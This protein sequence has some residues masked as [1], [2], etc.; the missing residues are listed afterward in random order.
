VV[1]GFVARTQAI[2]NIYEPVGL[3]AT[4]MLRR[5]DLGQAVSVATPSENDMYVFGIVDRLTGIT[6]ATIT[7]ER[8]KAGNCVDL[9]YIGGPDIPHTLSAVTH[10]PPSYAKDGVE[11]MAK[12]M[13]Q[14]QP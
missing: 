5:S 11:L 14:E 6:P 2:R 12:L 7:P 3:I 10:T 4:N 8:R 9:M 13:S 1:L